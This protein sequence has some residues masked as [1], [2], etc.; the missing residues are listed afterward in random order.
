MA[1]WTETGALVERA[2]AAGLQISVGVTGPHKA[3]EGSHYAM[4]GRWY[5]P[6]EPVWTYN[7]DVQ[8]A[9]SEACSKQLEALPAGTEKKQ[10]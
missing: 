9:I 2:L 6:P 4:C 7:D 3:S 1:D 10:G 5:S 8:A